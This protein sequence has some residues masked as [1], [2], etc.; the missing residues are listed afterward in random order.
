MKIDV[1]TAKLLVGKDVESS[2][3][4]YLSE[5]SHKQAFKEVKS[6]LTLM[7]GKRTVIEAK[8]V[9]IEKL[10]KQVEELQSYIKIMTALNNKQLIEQ[11]VEQLKAQGFKETFV[12]GDRENIYYS[13]E[14]D[15]SLNFK[16]KR[17]DAQ[18]ID[19][20]TCRT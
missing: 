3:L 12:F 10:K 18:A 8:D 17:G 5:V 16:V 11:A 4:T 6:V 19:N 14:T 2:M 7:N 1:N 20:Q 15:K 13:N 9:E